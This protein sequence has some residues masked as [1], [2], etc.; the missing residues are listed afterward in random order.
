MVPT[1]PANLIMVII[2]LFVV[3]IGIFMSRGIYFATIDELNIP[4][5]LTGAAI[6]FAS[7]I[8]FMPEAFVYTL[9]GN[10]LDTYPGT[11]GYHILFIY[12]LVFAVVGTAAAFILYRRIK[13][14]KTNP[15]KEISQ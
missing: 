1:G 4:M 3:A 9:V 14:Q 7:V 11:Q 12:M 5:H 10:W 13:K 15:A 8:G 6:G 2:A